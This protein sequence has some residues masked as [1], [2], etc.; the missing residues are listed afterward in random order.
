M[1]EDFF[2]PSL[3]FG[4]LLTTSIIRLLSIS[5]SFEKIQSTGKIYTRIVHT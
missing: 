5:L 3:G 4:H 2:S 1:L